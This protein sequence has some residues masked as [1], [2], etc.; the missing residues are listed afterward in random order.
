MC[1]SIL[2]SSSMQQ[3]PLIYCRGTLTSIVIRYTLIEINVIGRL[4]CI[5]Y[6]LRPCAIKNIQYIPHVGTQDIHRALTQDQKASK[7]KRKRQV[8]FWKQSM[9]LCFYWGVS[10]ESLSGISVP[11]ENLLRLQP[12]NGVDQPDQTAIGNWLVA[13]SVTH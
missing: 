2:F 10:L 3:L 7:K 4:C 11:F 6:L 13:K 5:E 1:K 12:V 9:R 8:L